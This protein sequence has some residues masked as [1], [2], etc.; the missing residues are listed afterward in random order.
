MITDH[1]TFV[2][3]LVPILWVDDL[4][5]VL[6]GVPLVTLPLEESLPFATFL[7]LIY[8]TV[9]NEVTNFT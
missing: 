5:D 6:F 2:T 3:P 9:L 7:I 4:G 8:F 1:T